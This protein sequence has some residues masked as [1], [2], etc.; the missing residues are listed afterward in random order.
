MCVLDTHTDHSE[1]TGRAFAVR[2]RAQTAI[3]R[4]IDGTQA[5]GTGEGGRHASPFAHCTVSRSHNSC[6]FS[7]AA[8]LLDQ[9]VLILTREIQPEDSARKDNYHAT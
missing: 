5:A 7:I 4:R 9:F 6:L 2:G 1:R 8:L 3:L